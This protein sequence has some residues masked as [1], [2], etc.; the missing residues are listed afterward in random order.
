MVIFGTILQL[1]IDRDSLAGVN[2]DAKATDFHE[3]QLNLW[4]VRGELFH[5]LSFVFSTI[6]SVVVVVVVVVNL[7]HK[8]NVYVYIGVTQRQILYFMS[9]KLKEKRKK[10]KAGTPVATAEAGEATVMQRLSTKKMSRSFIF[11]KHR[12]AT[13][14]CFN[15]SRAKFLL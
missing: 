6:E 2:F 5:C 8:L 12:T 15:R 9:V 10:R 13:S 1:C 7:V 3:Q 4:K 14:K 11:T